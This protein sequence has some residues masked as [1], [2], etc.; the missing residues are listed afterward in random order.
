VIAVRDRLTGWRGIGAGGAVGRAA[1]L[2]SRPTANPS[3]VTQC[4][5]CGV[6]RPVN[7]TTYLPMQGFTRWSN[8]QQ[9]VFDYLFLPATP[10]R[11]AKLRPVVPAGYTRT[12]CA[13]APGQHLKT[14]KK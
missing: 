2:H 13:Q 9:S 4:R 14:I 6:Q 7:A 11:L 12:G 5:G 1:G 8:G 3:P 10:Q